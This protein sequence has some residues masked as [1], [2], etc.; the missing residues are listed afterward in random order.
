MQKAPL[1]GAFFL[2][3]FKARI[4]FI[5]GFEKK[6]RGRGVFKWL[7]AG[8]HLVQRSSRG[9]GQV[10]TVLFQRNLRGSLPRHLKIDS[11]RPQM[12][13]EFILKKLFVKRL[14]TNS[15]YIFMYNIFLF[16]FLSHKERASFFCNCKSF[17]FF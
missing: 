1:T 9:T 15:F 4:I 3:F 13:K 5:I 6:I 17:T 7:E 8:E 16:Y 12:F 14:L 2:Y 10:G 11:A